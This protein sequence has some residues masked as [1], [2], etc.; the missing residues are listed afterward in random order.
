MKKLLL[1]ESTSIPT[2]TD[3]TTIQNILDNHTAVGNSMKAD[4]LNPVKEYVSIT[5]FKAELSK[6]EIN[7]WI[8]VKELGDV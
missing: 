8:W 4:F 7:T 5:R 6:L 2:P 1:V 3:M